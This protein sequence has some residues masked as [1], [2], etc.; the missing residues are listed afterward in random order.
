MNFADVRITAQFMPAGGKFSLS[1]L[2]V[3]GLCPGAL[4]PAA[5]SVHAVRNSSD[6]RLA[7]VS[8]AA[9]GSGTGAEF[10][11]VRYGAARDRMFGNYQVEQGSTDLTIASLNAGVAYFVAVDSV[12]GTGVTKGSAVVQV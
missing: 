11:I 10:Y 6:P 8:W 4:P 5:V 3:F 9:G 7:H 12:G 1:G 2:R